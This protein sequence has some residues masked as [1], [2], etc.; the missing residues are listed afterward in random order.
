M[1]RSI[2]SFTKNLPTTFSVIGISPP[3]DVTLKG[4][5]KGTVRFAGIEAL[6]K[7]L[8]AP[9]SIRNFNMVLFFNLY[10]K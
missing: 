7:F 8:F 2:P 4:L 10:S 6:I 1:G 5:V 9:V 3:A